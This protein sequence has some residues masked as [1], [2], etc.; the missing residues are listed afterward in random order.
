MKNWY[1]LIWWIVAPIFKVFHPCKLVGENH[2]P[3]NGGLLCA[4]HSSWSDPVC[5]AVALGHK[6]QLRAMAKAELMRI[7]VIGW[8][9]KKAGIF[10]VER[11]QADMSAIKTAM[12]HL[13]NEENVLVFP[14]GT[15]VRNGVDKHG[16]KAEAKTG[17]A[18]LAVR[19]GVKI[20]PIY[21]PVKKN[22]FKVTKIVI[23]EPYLPC[24]KSKK[25]TPEEYQ[26]ITDDLMGRI[27]ALEELSK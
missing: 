21:I 18:M 1:N 6:R 5:L 11:G 22:W 3:Q 16:N 15:R 26:L 10:A 20:V 23:G 14:E 25:G 4:N 9:L 17:A 7:P 2:F 24:I 19:T 27:H 12:K 8:L 13:K